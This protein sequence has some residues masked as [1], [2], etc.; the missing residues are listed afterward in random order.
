[1]CGA[2]RGTGE[3]SVLLRNVPTGSCVVTA[4]GVTARVEVDRPRG[5][6]CSLANG[7]LSCR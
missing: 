7:A 2:V 1:V 5:F 6:T 3:G 4:G